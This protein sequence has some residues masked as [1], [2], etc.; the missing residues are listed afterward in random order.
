MVETILN[1]LLL[2][3]S[4]R[5]GRAS[6]VQGPPVRVLLKT[7]LAVVRPL[8]RRDRLAWREWRMRLA[9]D[10]GLADGYLRY[11]VLH[12]TP[13]RRTGEGLSE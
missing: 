2:T 1:N 11:Q 10:A 13:R 5:W 3:R 8:A 6:I 7:C 9:R 4:G 12:R